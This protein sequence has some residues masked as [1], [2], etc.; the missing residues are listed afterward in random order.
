MLSTFSAR[1]GINDYILLAFVFACYMVPQ[2]F[3]PHPFGGSG[4][5]YRTGDLVKE[6]PVSSAAVVR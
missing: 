2:R 1:C 3:I 6:L 4:L 5:V